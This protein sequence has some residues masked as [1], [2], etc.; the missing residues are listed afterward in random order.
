MDDHPKSPLFTCDLKFPFWQQLQ[1][2]VPFLR[3]DVE[4]GSLFL[5]YIH[6]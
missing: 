4:G 6:Q 1:K 3:D 5:M 2:A